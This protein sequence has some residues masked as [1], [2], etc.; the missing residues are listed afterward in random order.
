[1]NYLRCII[2]RAGVVV[3]CLLLLSPSG[4]RSVSPAAVQ[5]LHSDSAAAHLTPV[6][7]PASEVSAPP[8]LS[9]DAPATPL[10]ALT[11]Q[12]RDNRP[13][14][15]QGDSSYENVTLTEDVT[16]RGT[17]L[18]RGYLVIAPQATVRVEAGTVV[19]FMKSPILRQAPRLVVMGRL[20][21][22]GTPEKPVLFAPN[23]A[24]PAS[25][26]W[27]G[28][29]LLSS[30]KRNQ[31][32]NVRIKGAEIGIE[33]RFSTLVVKGGHFT[34]NATALLLRDC[35]A[36]LSNLAVSGAETALD[37]QDSEIDLKESR[38]EYNRR[39]IVARHA[40][41][42]LGAVSVR[43]SVLQGI[44][45]DD[46]RI[47]FIA[48]E[49]TGNGGGARLNGGEGHIVLTRFVRNR[50]VGLQLVNAR[51][52]IN[53]CLFADTSGDGIRMNDGRSVV[54]GSSFTGNSG[55]NL[56]NAG[57]DHISAVQNWWGSARDKDISAKLFDAAADARIGRIMISPWLAEKPAALP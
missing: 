23:N 33:A 15:T 43:D 8:L 40:T 3:W 32:D 13:L 30:E 36:T 18:I 20:Q 56:A 45:A 28:I 6:P 19:R 38:L 47:R 35:T 14:V 7:S 31:F 25:G 46:C 4:C 1:M 26:D 27:A 22:S 51:V 34:R 12:V 42:V 29:L 5:E 37:V 52:K 2:A 57:P 11:D 17:I 53:Q 49:V 10:H 41:L 16:W 50:D 9:P 54:W 39:A 48:C 44:T 55:F 24:D 21:C